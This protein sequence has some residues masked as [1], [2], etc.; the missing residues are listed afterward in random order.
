MST[1]SESSGRRRAVRSG[2][3]AVGLAALVGS[4]LA[5]PP[6]LERSTSD[7]L[8]VLT[9][10]EQHALDAA[11]AASG[12][13]QDEAVVATSSRAGLAALAAAF[14]QEGKQYL[15]GGTGPDSWD[16]SG[17]VQWAFRQ[18]GVDLPRLSWDQ[19]E[20][21]E[22]VDVTDMAPGDVVSFREEADHIG[23][24][25]GAGMVFNAYDVDRP[26]GL[27]ALTDLPPINTVRR[28]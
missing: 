17:L 18:A 3:A 19:A 28:L 25:A 13:E 12:T 10:A 14:T 4:A 21:G 20:I 24:Y 27:T 8:S 5:I 22:P 23:I 7:R 9:A 1:T 16:C 26:I 2:L 11:A 6:L 15:Y